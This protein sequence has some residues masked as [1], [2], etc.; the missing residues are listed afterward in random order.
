MEWEQSTLALCPLDP[1]EYLVKWMCWEDLRN[2]EIDKMKGG[3]SPC[4]GGLH[5]WLEGCSHYDPAGSGH[6]LGMRQ[7]LSLEQLHAPNSTKLTVRPLPL[8]IVLCYIWWTINWMIDYSMLQNLQE[9]GIL[10][11]YSGFPSG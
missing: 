11:P 6:W 9:L 8:H 10:F 3:L 2:W 4:G 5:P 7:S 1:L